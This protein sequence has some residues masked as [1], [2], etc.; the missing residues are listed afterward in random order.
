MQKLH[1]VGLTTDL[2]GLIFSARKGAKS[3]SYVIPLDAQLV[4]VIADTVQRRNGTGDE[5]GFDVD[6]LEEAAAAGGGRGATRRPLRAVA[7]QQSAL[8]PREIQARL[9][10]GRTIDDVAKA[11]GVDVAWVERFAVPILAE[12]RRVIDKAIV[13]VFTKPRVGVS[14][15]PLGVAVRRNLADRGVR[16]G[17]DEF[18]QGWGAHQLEESRWV[19]R[20][21]YTSRGRAQVAEWDVD[22]ADGS[23]VSRNRLGGQLAHVGPK[24]RRTPAARTPAKKKSAVKKR[25]SPAK[26]KAAAKKRAARPLRAKPR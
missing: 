5:E 16:L 14:S 6:A 4:A 20:F 24:R 22:L 7:R 18:D 25:A 26:K 23:V 12:Q 1:L 11:A 13:F 8:T 2:T 17:D 10:A 21:S 3:G 15:Q 19:V 9:R